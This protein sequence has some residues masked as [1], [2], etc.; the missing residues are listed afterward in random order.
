MAKQKNKT[1]DTDAQIAQLVSKL[2]SNDKRLAEA[3]TARTGSKLKKSYDKLKAKVEDRETRTHKLTVDFG[4]GAVAQ[5]S[6]EFI[7][8]LIRLW[9]EYRPCLLYTSRCV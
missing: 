4:G 9:A 3:G 5:I 2:D 1:K 8:G 6:N 7:N